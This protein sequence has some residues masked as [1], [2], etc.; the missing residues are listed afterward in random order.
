[1]TEEEKKIVKGCIA[2]DTNSQKQLYQQYGPMILG[3]CRMY[4]NN[5][6]AEAED[7]FHDT[8]IF[9]LTHFQKYTHISSLAGWLRTIAVNKAIDYCRAK[10]R[11]IIETSNQP[12]EKA[13]PSSTNHAN[14]ILTM[15]QLMTYI[16]ELPHKYRDA[17]CYN[18]LE[19]RSQTEIEELMGETATNVR[20]L[21]SRAKKML[22]EK[23]QHYLNHEEFI[24]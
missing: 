3:V 17:F 5:D 16:N 24:L 23:I 10:Q 21:I 19:G 12:I 6:E 4:T 11:S 20:T 15:A 22:R 18:I 1:M 13:D 8:F 7:L 2:G 14:E 9:I